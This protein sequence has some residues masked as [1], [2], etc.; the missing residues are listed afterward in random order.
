MKKR[1][2]NYVSDITL[3]GYQYA[4]ERGCIVEY[5]YNKTRNRRCAFR[6]SESG[7]VEA[8]GIRNLDAEDQWSEMLRLF[9]DAASAD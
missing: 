6:L 5:D 8:D 3:N 2:N 7:R 1:L 9:N 4:I